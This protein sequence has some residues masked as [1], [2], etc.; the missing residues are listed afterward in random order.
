MA[1]RVKEA[2]SFDENGVPVTMRVGQLVDGDDPRIKGREHLYEDADVA[3]ARMSDRSTESVGSVETASA[4]PGEKR[5]RRSTGS[6][7]D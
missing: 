5:S 7:A 2:H 1:K 3:A 4:A 6:A